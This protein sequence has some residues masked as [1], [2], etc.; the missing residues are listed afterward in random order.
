M[1]VVGAN[2][3]YI[4]SHL[5]NE[6]WRSQSAAE[7][8]LLV[9]SVLIMIIIILVV[10]Y[11]C[12]HTARCLDMARRHGLRR[13][14]SVN[15]AVLPQDAQCSCADENTAFK[16]PPFCLSGDEQHSLLKVYAC[17]A[18]NAYTAY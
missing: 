12:T 8:T 6:Q 2:V 5:R 13:L 11:V 17:S 1:S 16:V 3:P 14:P 7:V 10:L 18:H 4:R 9:R 15:C